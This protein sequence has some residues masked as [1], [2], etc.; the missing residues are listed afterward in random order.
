MILCA[1][2]GWSKLAH[3]RRHF[4]RFRRP[5]VMQERHKGNLAYKDMET[6]KARTSLRW[7]VLGSMHRCQ[8]YLIWRKGKAPPRLRGLI[9]YVVIC[10]MGKVTFYRGSDRI[11]PSKSCKMWIEVVLFIVLHFYETFWNILACNDVIIYRFLPNHEKIVWKVWAFYFPIGRIT[12]N[13]VR[14][15]NIPFAVHTINRLEFSVIMFTG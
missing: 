9:W 5:P 14:R 13:T 7:S 4:F 8:F 10:K 3:A 2:T 15:E 1:C 11:T 6:A 12:W